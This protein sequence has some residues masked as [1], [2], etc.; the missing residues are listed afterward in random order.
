[1]PFV[2]G[3]KL[4]AQN[5]GVATALEGARGGGPELSR[6]TATRTNMKT[7]LKLQVPKAIPLL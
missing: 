4:A 5:E 2:L 6:N 1:M 3:Q 7:E